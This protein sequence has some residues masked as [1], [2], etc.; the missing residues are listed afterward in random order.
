MFKLNFKCKVSIRTFQLINLGY[1]F[2]HILLRVTVYVK[3]YIY[4]NI[5]KITDRYMRHLINELFALSAQLGIR[6]MTILMKSLQILRG[7]SLTEYHI[8]AN[9]LFFN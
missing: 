2:L 5:H 7:G 3:T 4:Q 6:V 1:F 9:N 8:N